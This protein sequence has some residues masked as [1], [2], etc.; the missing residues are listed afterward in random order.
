MNPLIESKLPSKKLIKDTMIDSSVESTD[1]NP[2]V[3]KLEELKNFVIDTLND[4]YNR[5]RPTFSGWIP[6]E[7]NKKY[8]IQFDEESTT[9]II[10][11]SYLATDETVLTSSELLS[12]NKTTRGISIRD[13]SSKGFSIVTGEKSLHTGYEITTGSIGIF[14]L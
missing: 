11:A 3:D 10:L 5:S 9:P 12:I 14:Y 6:V 1:K 4:S 2:N 13:I 8:D 7:L